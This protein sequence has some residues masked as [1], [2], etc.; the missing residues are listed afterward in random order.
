MKRA[1]WRIVIAVLVTVALVLLVQAAIAATTKSGGPI[2]KV[3]VVRGGDYLHVTSTSFVD[4]PGATT[5][6]KVP[7][8]QQA[9]LIMRL[10]AETSCVGGTVGSD[11]C[12]ARIVVNGTEAEPSNS[13]DPITPFAIDSVSSDYA[14]EGH[15]M[16]RSLGP[17]SPGTY[18]VK[19]QARVTTSGVDL[20]LDDWHLTVERV[21]V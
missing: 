15:A 20:S 14:W 21:K 8:G 19:V 12:E 17:L 9:L 3:K 7:V 1:P 13:L 10:T 5:K 11:W 6:M 18:T 4:V 2:V 16:D